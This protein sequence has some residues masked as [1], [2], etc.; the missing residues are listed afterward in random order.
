MKNPGFVQKVLMYRAL[1]NQILMSCADGSIWMTFSSTVL[2]FRYLLDDVVLGVVIIINNNWISQT[3]IMFLCPCWYAYFWTFF[4]SPFLK[5]RDRVLFF[6]ELN[7]SPRLNK[8]GSPFI[9]TTC[10]VGWQLGRFSLSASLWM[11]LERNV[12]GEFALSRLVVLYVCVCVDVASNFHHVF[13][14]FLDSFV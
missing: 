14:L 12:S 5:K 9:Y 4:L 1:H 8:M 13:P 10:I 11:L 7:R 2:F 3:Q 6:L